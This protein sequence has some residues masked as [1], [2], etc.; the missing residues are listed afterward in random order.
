MARHPFETAGLSLLVLMILGCIVG[1]IMIQTGSLARYPW[2]IA[3]GGL[4]I[5]A[6]LGGLVFGFARSTRA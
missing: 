3:F 5:M 1:F 4:G 2:V 6:S